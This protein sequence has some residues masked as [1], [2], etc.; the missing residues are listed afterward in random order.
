M[1]IAKQLMEDKIPITRI[2]YGRK[3]F[4]IKIYRKK[5]TVT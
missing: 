2:I 5:E 4:V 3:A 1:R